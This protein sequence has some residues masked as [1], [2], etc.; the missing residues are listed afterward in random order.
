MFSFSIIS[1]LPVTVIP[2]EEGASLSF[3]VVVV[4]KRADAS[5]D[6]QYCCQRDVETSLLMMSHAT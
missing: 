3:D 4:V 6:M 2:E 1:L 5:T